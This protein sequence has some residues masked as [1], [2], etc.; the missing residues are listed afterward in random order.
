MSYQSETDWD[1]CYYDF[2]E[3]FQGICY[4]DIS[5]REVYNETDGARLDFI[6]EPKQLIADTNCRKHSYDE[7]Y[8]NKFRNRQQA[9]SYCINGLYK[10]TS[11]AQG[12]AV[13]WKTLQEDMINDCGKFEGYIRMPEIT[14]EPIYWRSVNMQ[15]VTGYTP[16]EDK[17][18]RRD[19]SLMSGM[20]GITKDGTL[21][22][23]EPVN[24][25]ST[26]PTWI[27]TMQSAKPVFEPN[28]MRAF[29]IGTIQRNYSPPF[30]WFKKSHAYIDKMVALTYLPNPTNSNHIKHIDKNHENCCLDNLEWVECVKP[31][32]VL[33]GT[34]Y[35][36]N[37]GEFWVEGPYTKEGNEYTVTEYTQRISFNSKAQLGNYIGCAKQ[38]VSAAFKRNAEYIYS[39]TTGYWKLGETKHYEYDVIEISLEE[40]NDNSVTKRFKTINDIR[41]E[42]GLTTNAIIESYKLGVDIRKQN[43]FIRIRKVVVDNE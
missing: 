36:K 14:K 17:I 22:Y 18:L 16:P 23:L 34:D 11:F 4:V 40:G 33:N 19:E 28:V 9:I 27:S 38:T 32:N 35:H 24:V 39:K 21:F 43:Y 6:V 3:W 7:V 13:C 20:Y 37:T 31:S 5:G 25:V 30:I 12:N 8:V 10:L 41:V 1:C 2:D 26:Y 15:K 29:C 42:Y